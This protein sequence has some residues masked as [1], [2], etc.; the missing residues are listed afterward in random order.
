MSWTALGTLLL[1]VFTWQKPGRSA[2]DTVMRAFELG[3]GAGARR[4]PVAAS[5]HGLLYDMVRIGSMLSKKGLEK[6]HEA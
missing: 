2:I 1:L 6:A 5:H 4:R 3:V